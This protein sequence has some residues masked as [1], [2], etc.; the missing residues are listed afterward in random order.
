MQPAVSSL[1]LLEF[2]RFPCVVALCSS[3]VHWGAVGSLGQL[4]ADLYSP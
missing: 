1:F 2:S 3:K 4:L